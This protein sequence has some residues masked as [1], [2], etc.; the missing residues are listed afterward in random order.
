MTPGPGD[1][2]RQR[3]SRLGQ[4]RCLMGIGGMSGRTKVKTLR[5]SHVQG[6]TEGRSPILLVRTRHHLMILFFWK[7]LRTLPSCL[8]ETP[9]LVAGLREQTSR[10]TAEQRR[11]QDALGSQ[12]KGEVMRAPARWEGGCR[13]PRWRVLHTYQRHFPKD[14]RLYSKWA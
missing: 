8:Q 3:L 9:G 14:L 1:P 13:G 7:N 4:R 10:R 6:P 12:E 11:R 5:V 2:S